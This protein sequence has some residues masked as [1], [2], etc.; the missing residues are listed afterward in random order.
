MIRPDLLGVVERMRGAV[1]GSQDSHIASV[2]QL[3]SVEAAR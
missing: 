1:R 3:S 2:W